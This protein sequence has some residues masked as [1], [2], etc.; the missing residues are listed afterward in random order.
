MDHLPANIPII[1]ASASPRRHELFGLLNVPFQ[2]RTSDVDETPLRGEAPAETA[3]RLSRMKAQAV[4]EGL[5]EEWVVAADTVV[6]LDDHLLGKPADAAEATSILNRLRARMHQ[7]ITGV[8]LM[9]A[10]APDARTLAVCTDVW[11]RDYSDA[12]IAA[13]VASGDPLDKAGAYAIQHAKF[14]PVRRL[15]GC[16]AN[17]MG[18]PVCRVYKLLEDYGVMLPSVPAAGCRPAA[19]RCMIRQMVVPD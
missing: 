14:A 13:Y 19:S 17:V 5:A 1:L 16:P 12:E 2:V 15:V 18:L 8:T 6:A 9:G 3:V 7:V 11:M 4:A 10:G